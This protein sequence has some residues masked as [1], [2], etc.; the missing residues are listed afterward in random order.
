M[1]ELKKTLG[2]PSII[3]L[4]LT[5][6]LGTGMFFG[7]SIAAQTN[8]LGN[9]SLIA[10]A[11]LAAIAIYVS[12]CFA[13][14]SSMFPN[15][16]GVY[17][18]AKQAYGRFASFMIGWTTWLVGNITA[19]VM[20]VA[21]MSYLFPAAHHELLR[22]GVSLGLLVVLN[23]VAFRGIEASTRV[24]IVISS[25]TL[26]AI[27]AVIVPGTLEIQPDNYQ[28][29]L[30]V[31]A[32]LIFVSLFFIM[33]SLFGWESATF[34]SEET[35]NA[36]KVIPRS[37]IIATVLAATIALAIPV[38]TLGVIPWH[39][40]GEGPFLQLATQI[41]GMGSSKIFAGAVVL[42]MIGASAGIVVSNPRLLLALARDKL[43][44]EQLS[45]IHTKYRTPYKAIFFQMFV[46]IVVLLVGFGAYEK[47]LS[48]LVPLALLMYISVLLAVVIL[49]FK[50]PYRVRSYKAP[51]GK[52]LPIL[53]ALF[54]LFVIV[55]W[56]YFDP[57]GLSL[58]QMALSFILFGVPIFLLLLFYYNPTTVIG[59]NNAFA[60][61]SMAF[62]NWTLPKKI[63]RDILSIFRDIQNKT[64]LEYGA[65]VGT[66]TLHLAERIGPAGKLIATDVSYKNLV[67][68]QKRLRKKGFTNIIILHDEHQFNRIHPDVGK[69]DAVF[70]VGMLGYLQDVPKVLKEMNELLPDQGR[71][72]MVDYVNFFKILPDPKWLTKDAT[73]Q[74]QFRQAGF[75][76]KVARKKGLLWSYLVIY[77]MKTPY[78]VPFI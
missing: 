44:I 54:Y 59:F 16:G 34:L 3:A 35:I 8:N 60:G 70:S 2:Y 78:D 40:L 11:L 53:V 64:V 61:L 6:M 57:Q 77:G 21:G 51:L 48:L 75:S 62:E 9:A 74:H 25:I 5:A 30:T 38:V 1:A 72:C 49:R 37:L 24:L 76:V 45:D 18:F 68:L 7:T 14:L 19:T 63:R 65:G 43:F 23:L 12:L 67:L 4:S 26:I 66:L 58:L 46:S 42:T 20:I 27:L 17:E 73:I 13:E 28:P 47:L 69:V 39:S 32:Y 31:P 33:E 41:Y 50:A 52:F 55:A 36:E 29:F 15:A 71:I 22:L 10:W 56:A